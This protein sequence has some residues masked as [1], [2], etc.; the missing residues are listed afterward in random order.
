MIISIQIEKEEDSTAVFAFLEGADSVKVETVL[1]GK[2]AEKLKE[3]QKIAVFG[4]EVAY[5]SGG[6]LVTLY[7]CELAP[8]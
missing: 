8:K 5:A 1:Y 6:G 3:G 2:D 7:E 4:K